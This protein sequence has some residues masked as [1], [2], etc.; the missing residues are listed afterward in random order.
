[1]FLAVCWLAAGLV[2]AGNLYVTLSAIRVT[3]QTRY[4]QF[5]PKENPA[6]WQPQEEMLAWLRLNAPDDAVVA[7]E[8][9]PVVFL[10]TGRRALCPF[11]YRQLAL[12]Y[13]Q[14][15][16]KVGTVEEWRQLMLRGQVRYLVTAT[17][18]LYAQ[19]EPFHAL[20]AQV[21]KE[22][23]DWLSPVYQSAIDPQ[24]VIYMIHLEKM[25]K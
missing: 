4:P 19:N 12:F 5:V 17:L 3:Q 25:G 18:P 10:Y 7:A 11:A 22:H 2:V 23:P 8:L 9:D 24:G 21:R 20:I 14:P 6:V 13:G 16:P 15:E 1:L